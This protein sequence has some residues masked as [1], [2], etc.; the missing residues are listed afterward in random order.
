MSLQTLQDP[1]EASQATDG[2]VTGDELRLVRLRLAL[3][4]IATAVI[5]AVIASAIA[6][7]VLTG[8]SGLIGFAL[9][10]F[11]VPPAVVL[12]GI[13]V[14]SALLM[15]RLAH[16]VV[17]PAEELDAARRHF[18]AL[19]ETA[20]SDALVDSLTGL[21][22]HRAFQEE[23]DRQLDAVRRYNQQIALL[24]IDLDDFKTINDAAGHAV[25]DKAL[26][27]I[28]RLLRGGLRRSDR[29]FRVGGDEFAV[30]MPGTQGA[31]AHTV[32][33][34]ILSS[35]LEPRRDSG[36]ERGF[37]FSA[38]IAAAPLMGVSRTDLYA[39]ADVAL[40]QSKRE[41]RTAV[42]V[43]DESHDDRPLEGERLARAAHAVV[44]VVAGDAISP[45]Y[46]PIV[47]VRSGVVVG[48]EGLS[49]P[50]LGTSFSDAASLFSLAEATG[51]TADLDWVCIR[52]IVKGA[53]SLRPDQTLSLNLS[54]KTVE[55]AEFQPQP[56]L[57]LIARAGIAP[58]RIVLEITE[59]QGVDN[60]DALRAKLGACREAG[61]RIAIDDVGAGNSG[62]RLLSQIHFDIVKIDLSLVH[63]GAQREASLDVVRSL[64]ELATRW[65]AYAVAEGVETP[66][67]LRMIRSIGLG[68]AQGYLLG[69]PMAEPNLVRIDIDEKLAE[70]N[71]SAMLRALAIGAA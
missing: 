2:G 11:P 13:V 65:G 16:Q 56:L 44:E 35:C 28:S 52:S 50:A 41:G 66:A 45:V 14:G 51:R 9:G 71:G 27:E 10:F 39:K 40:Y 8:P 15:R 46:Q 42:S 29:A 43:Y 18:G 12:G 34:R 57:G 38:G 48:F 55:A 21:G 24:L 61:F 69:R 3:V 68:H 54:P 22:N 59:R 5:S 67:M 64:S 60:L 37:S 33:R 6:V 4:V 49:R 26:V 20:L 31:E 47:D 62:L 63:A 19:Y 30:L 23:F 58:Q 53:A 25:G 17:H 7:V 36:F 70:P 32:A 1:N